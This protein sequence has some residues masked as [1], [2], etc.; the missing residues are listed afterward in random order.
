MHHIRAK[1]ALGQNFLTDE[2][3]LSTIAGGISVSG[4]NIIEVGPGYGALTDYLIAR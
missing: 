1:K 2:N 3:I 4:K